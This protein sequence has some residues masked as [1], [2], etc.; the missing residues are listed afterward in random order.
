MDLKKTGR[1]ISKKRKALSLKQ[2]QLAKML[3]VTPQA[4]S[5]WE[6]GLRFPD[7][8][9]QVRIFHVLGLNPVELIVGVEM[10]DDDLK[11]DIAQYM[12]RIDEKVLTGYNI[13]KSDG[14]KEHLDMTGF[15]VVTTGKDGTLSDKW[16]P[17]SDYYNVE[18]TD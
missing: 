1:L 16:V 17:Y 15:S 14:S 11:H 8:D 4:V 6:K 18:K 12:N 2:D 9:A 13:I 7:P 3:F 5:L 10:F